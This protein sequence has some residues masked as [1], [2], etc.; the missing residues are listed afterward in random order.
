[1]SLTQAT[2]RSRDKAQVLHAAACRK[3]LSSSQKVAPNE[4]TIRL[5]LA[6]ET[7]AFNVLIATHAD[8]VSALKQSLDNAAHVEYMEA[9]E[10]TLVLPPTKPW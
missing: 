7:E 9:R 3:L 1:M 6:K 2:K 4:R 10:T 5:D 8:H